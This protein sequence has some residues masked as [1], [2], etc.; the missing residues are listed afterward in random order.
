MSQ[1][2][3]IPFSVDEKAEYI[4]SALRKGILLT[5][6]ADGK[7]DT[8][9]IGWGALGIDWSEPVFIVYVRDSRYTKKLLDANGE[10]TLNIPLPDQDARRILSFA[11]TRSGRDVDKLEELNLHTVKGS[12]VS[13]PGILEVPMTVE[14]RVLYQQKQDPAAIPE[15]ILSSHYPLSDFHTAYTARIVDAYILQE[16]DEA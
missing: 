14:C 11:G 6:S 12:A 1:I 16:T 13:V 2:E 5:T 4:L 8:M 10:F 3:K 7:T 15:E 9:T